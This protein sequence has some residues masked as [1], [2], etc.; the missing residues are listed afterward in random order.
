MQSEPATADELNSQVAERLRQINQRLIALGVPGQALTIVAVTKGGS[1]AQAEAALANGL[2]DLGENY[3]AELK[4]KAQAVA[5]QGWEPV[6][7]HYLGK[8]QSNK[9]NRLAGIVSVWQTIDNLRTAKKLAR[10]WPVSNVF[11]EVNTSGDPRRPGVAPSGVEELVEGCESEELNVKGL[12]CLA[13]QGNPELAEADFAQCAELADSLGL[14]EL[15]MGMSDDYEL[16]VKHGATM[17][18]LGRIL[19]DPDYPI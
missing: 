17:L 2:A 9:I 5:E 7:W 8:L 19:F 14:P 3:A 6:I 1:V 10:R 18:R 15:S 4:S 13:R 12:M 11:I 16:A